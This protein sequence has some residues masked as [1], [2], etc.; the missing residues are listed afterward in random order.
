MQFPYKISKFLATKI[1]F[2]LNIYNIYINETPNT[3]INVFDILFIVN[4]HIC[5]EISS[6]NC[7]LGVGENKIHVKE[8]YIADTTI[9]FVLY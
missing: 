2:F 7:S 4:Y 1:I 6:C 8:L 3:Y 9:S 5:K